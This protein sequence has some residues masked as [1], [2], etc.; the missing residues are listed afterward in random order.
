LI[1]AAVASPGEVGSTQSAHAVRDL[2]LDR[3]TQGAYP[4]GGKLPTAKTLAVE[5]GLHHNTVA[6]AYRM[7]A[8]LGL[9]SIQ[10]G[11]GTFVVARP[12]ATNHRVLASHVHAA[13][14]SRVRHARRAGFSEEDLLAAVQRE[15]A[16]IYHPPQL[17]AA[18]VE[19]NV[20]DIE[21]GIAEIEAMTG[22]RLEPLLLERIVGDP[23]AAF[24]DRNLVFTS[25]IHLK[26]V[27]NVLEPVR[28][29]VRVSGVYT[30]P[31]ED[32]MARIAQIPTGSSVGI[33]VNIAEGAQ[34]FES[35]INTV[36]RV[37]TRPLVM[38]TDA[39]LRRLDQEVDV[40]VC[41]R[42]WGPRI[43]GLHLTKPVIELSFHVSRQSALRV[44]ELLI[45]VGGSASIGIA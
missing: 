4:L 31:D 22:V 1:G 5:L 15:V 21:A 42:S 6:K 36:T 17:R 23:S 32:A 20:R 43:R 30:Q 12:D 24:A 38:P 8:D 14:T 45:G 40:I 28:P 35:Q 25:L 44:G 3:L 16:A 9:V 27:T 13:V 33:V 18:Y 26:E 41:S 34:R 29:D 39:E 7:L 2:L 10:Q 37:Q 11:R 19:C